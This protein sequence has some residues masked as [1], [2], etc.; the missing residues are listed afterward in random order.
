[1]SENIFNLPSHFTENVSEYKI[2]GFRLFSLRVL[3]T[4]L[5]CVLASKGTVEKGVML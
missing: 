5:H 4:S 1:M 3:K 2:L